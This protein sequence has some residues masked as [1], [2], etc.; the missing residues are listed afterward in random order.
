MAPNEYQKPKYSNSDIQELAKAFDILVEAAIQGHFI[1]Q[2]G[3]LII[4]CN[5]GD[6][7]DDWHYQASKIVI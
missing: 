7:N 4:D 3:N 2:K 5:S 1:D 6:S